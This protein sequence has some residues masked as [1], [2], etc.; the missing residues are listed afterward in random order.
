MNL[1]SQ[2]KSMNNLYPGGDLEGDARETADLRI[3]LKMPVMS[4]MEWL[5]ATWAFPMVCTSAQISRA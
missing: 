5:H 3:G 4:D 1:H 2:K